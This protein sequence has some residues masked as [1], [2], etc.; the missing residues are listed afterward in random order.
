MR[1]SDSIFAGNGYKK[2]F[3]QEKEGLCRLL[4]MS[5]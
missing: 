1:Q 3:G 5:A 2:A 4:T